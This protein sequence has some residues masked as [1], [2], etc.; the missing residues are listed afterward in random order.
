MAIYLRVDDFPGTKPEEFYRHNLAS[1]KEFDKLVRSF[2]PSY[3]LGVIPKHV[4]YEQLEYLGN[5]PHITVA[6]H[7]I[8]HDERFPNEFREHLTA[9]DIGQ[10]LLEV[11][12]RLDPLVGPIKTYM[13]PHNVF[14]E[15]TLRGL[16]MAQF[17]NLT[18]GPESPQDITLFGLRYFY[19]QA[20]LGYGRSDELLARGA[21]E[22]LKSQEEV[23]LTLHWTWEVN[24]GLQHLEAF[25]SQL[26]GQFAELPKGS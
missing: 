12:H 7:G 11:R 17:S 22:W 24:I 3:L 8:D 5:T 26:E 2:V 15:R 1:F 14:D 13:P 10:A 20:P 18:G 19:S 23:W 9:K 16:H 6:M 21:V 25:F 4:T